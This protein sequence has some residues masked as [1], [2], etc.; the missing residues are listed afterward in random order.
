M[1]IKSSGVYFALA[2]GALTLSTPL[3]AA[4]STNDVHDHDSHA[5]H[6]N[7]GHV[8]YLNDGQPWGTDEP[9]REAMGKLRG[10]VRASLDDIHTGNFADSAF[11]SLAATINGQVAY[12][13]E[14]CGLEG[15][16]DAQLHILITQLMAGASAMEG[17]TEDSRTSGAVKVVG[18]L[19]NYATYFGDESFEPIEH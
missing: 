13:I 3:V 7:E 4:T 5:V 8:L 12:M 16:A 10:R 1:S 2:L 19:N 15:E 9:L 18:A 6:A 14:N 17:A 11:D